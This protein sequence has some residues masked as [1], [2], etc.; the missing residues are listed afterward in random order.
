VD[1]LGEVV[2]QCWPKQE[3]HII[4]DNLPAHKTQAVRDFLARLHVRL[5]FTPTYSLW[6]NQFELWFA[7]IERDVS[8]RGVFTSAPD[9][10]RKLRR[11]INA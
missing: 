2:A 10:A 7:K 1:F 5:Q 3:I 6:R 9:L 11:H 4:L 8:A